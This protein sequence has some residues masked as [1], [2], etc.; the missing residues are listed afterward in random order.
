MASPGRSG[1][2]WPQV[3]DGEPVSR[4]KD[5]VAASSMAA[6]IRWALMIRAT[7]TSLPPSTTHLPLVLKK[8]YP[9]M[10]LALAKP[11]R[12]P[13]FMMPERS[14]RSIHSSRSSE[15]VGSGH[16]FV[17]K[18][19][20]FR[21]RGRC[22]EKSASYVPRPEPARGSAAKRMLVDRHQWRDS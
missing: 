1:C 18:A 19:S 10:L 3:H 6:R 15:Y 14:R 7:R 22:S 21:E 13:S 5:V 12:K 2:G 11:A 4:R 20:G 8:P 9:K 16:A 17:Q